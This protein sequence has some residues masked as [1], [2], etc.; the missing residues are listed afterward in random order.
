MSWL[1]KLLRPT[2]QPASGSTVISRAMWA[3]EGRLALK[4]DANRLSGEVDGFD[5]S[6]E[7]ERLHVGADRARAERL[8]LRARLPTRLDVGLRVTRSSESDPR[9]PLRTNDETFDASFLAVADEAERGRHFLGEDVRRVLLSGPETEL[10][11]AGVAVAVGETDAPR[12]AEAVR[13]TIG[14]AQALEQA[15]V[16]T[17][18]ATALAEF[19]AAWRGFGTTAPLRVESTPLVARIELGRVATTALAVRDGFGQFHFEL[20]ARFPAPL[21]IGLGLRPQNTTNEHGRE[22]EPVGERA[23]DRLFALTAR[24]MSAQPL[25]DTE[26]RARLVELRHAGL[27]IRANDR[28]LSAWMG[29]RKEDPMAPVR[30][31]WALADI[32]HSVLARVEALG[33]QHTTSAIE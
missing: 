20:T 8:L 15:R 19:E 2:P 26:V 4:G 9:R 29:C 18:A 14:L 21:E 30:H 28:V 25:F 5:F 11:D 13:H 17:P 10:S 31:L 7:R 3:C 23:F 1:D 22:A 27:Q 33:T 6:V 32:G 24:G 16:S 12:I